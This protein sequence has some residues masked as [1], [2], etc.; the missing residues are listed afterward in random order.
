[1]KE[2]Y[3]VARRA[4]EFGNDIG[5]SGRERE[6]AHFDRTQDEDVGEGLGGRED[7][8]DIVFL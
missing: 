5:D 4:G 2:G 3:A 8:E 7:A 6:S 1:M